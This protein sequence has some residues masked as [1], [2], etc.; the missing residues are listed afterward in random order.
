MKYIYLVG[1]LRVTGCTVCRADARYARSWKVLLTH[2]DIIPNSG[3]P[4][5]WGDPC[6]DEPVSVEDDS[7]IRVEHAEPCGFPMGKVSIKESP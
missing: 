4:T 1:P 5:H 7:S 3:D 6:L 2:L